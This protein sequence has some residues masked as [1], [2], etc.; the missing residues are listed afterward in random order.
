MRVS[1]AF[2]KMLAIPGAW[3]RE[4][5]FSPTGVVVE[6]R[7]RARRLQCPCGTTFS[8]TYDRSVRRWRHLDLGASRL[9]LQAEI[10]RGRCP[11]CRRVRTE[12]VPW[13]RPGARH[14]RDF[15]D[16]VTWLA[17]R[18]DKTTVAT[19]FGCAWATVDA[20][21]LR[22]VAD[23]IDDSRL[24]GLYRIGVD[25]VSYR[26]GHRF[27]TLVADH[28]TGAVVWASYQDPARAFGSFFDQLGPER[29]AQIQAVSMD[30]SPAFRGVASV[31]APQARVCFDPFH[32]IKRANVAVD[33]VFSSVAQDL[34]L[35]GRDVTRKRVVLR[36]AG[37]D[38]S[39]D[40]RRFVVMLRR[41]RHVLFRAWLL[42]EE[43][44]DFY[45]LELADPADYLKRWITRALRSKI[46]AFVRLAQ[47]L[48]QRFDGVL[49]A[50]ELGLSNSRLEGINARVRVIQRRGYG[51]HSPAALVAMIYLVCGGITV[52]LPTRR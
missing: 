9:W 36:R 42:K 30:M 52:Q 28:D 18:A 13:A 8:G 17:Q 32:I 43:L 15:E 16:V 10:R 47:L 24:D 19:L 39:R 12:Q 33:T 20:I 11:S 27:V 31:A 5:T 46:L 34:G 49:A 48:K 50:V 25:E 35:R 51:F 26:R 6:L 4:I 2:N 1:T 37:E 21:V 3:V 41:K 22:V 14:S 40:Q 44:R 7:R 29:S 45:R 23:H 38:L